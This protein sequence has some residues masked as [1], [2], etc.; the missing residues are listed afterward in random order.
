[1]SVLQDAP[2]RVAAPVA[3]GRDAGAD[4]F[5]M[6]RIAFAVAPVLF[7]LDKFFNVL[8]D[9]PKYL[10]G[11]VD[12]L[13][14]G[15][16]QDF[17][18]LVGGVEIL[19]GMLVAVRPRL[20]APV[21]VLWLGGIIVNLVSGPGYYD[22]ALRDFGLLLGALTLTRLAMAYDR[23]RRSSSSAPGLAGAK[24]A[25]TLRDEGFDGRVV[26]VGERGRPPVRAAAAVE[27]VP[28]RR[29]RARDGVR[30]PR[31]L[32]RR[33]RHRA[34]H[35][36]RAPRRSTGRARRSCWTTAS[37]C[38]TTRCCWPRAPSRAGCRSPAPTSTACCTCA[39]SR[40]SDALRARLERGG[41]VVVVGAGWI[42]CEVAASA[43]HARARRDRGRAAVGAARARARRRGSARST[44]TSTPTTAS[45]WRLGRGV[46]GVR[47]RGRRR[48]RA[49][50]RRHGRSSA[51]SSSSA[52]ACARGPGWRPPRGWPSATGCWST[53]SS[54][55]SAPGVFAAGDV[56]CAAHPFYGER[57]RVEHWATALEQGP[58]AARSML[59]AGDAY[60]RLPYFFSDQ[61]DVGMEYTGLARRWDRVVLPR[62]SPRRASSSRSGW[63]ATASSPG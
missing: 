57:V 37:R 1:M 61:Y 47:G 55:P 53:S 20:G 59:G 7:G 35:G 18:Y 30:A 38:A 39:S 24:A 49:A 46:D 23:S 44:A 52:S 13:M 56:A 60:D 14:P 19:A 10:A 54:R 4:A 41:S 12:D 11:W 27:G 29:V 16:A 63:T 22:V 17:M 8:T 32:L 26:L 33:A 25:E 28:A 31:G 5:L 42:G 15:S 48:A 58:A 3:A 50:E 43:R 40:D 2:G 36:S 9:W 62:R 34:A 51:T 6:L 45:D 21:V